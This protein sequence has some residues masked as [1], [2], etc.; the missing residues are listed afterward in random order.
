MF[1]K[2]KAP[3]ILSIGCVATYFII[4]LFQ[5]Y[6]PAAHEKVRKQ[7]LV[8]CDKLGKQARQLCI[9]RINSLGTHAEKTIVIKE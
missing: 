6:T 3:L 4:L 9:D 7:E 5:V 2:A 1:A 8:G